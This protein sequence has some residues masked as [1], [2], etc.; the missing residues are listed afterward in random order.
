MFKYKIT[1]L[2]G[3]FMNKLAVL[4]L[5]AN[6]VLVNAQDIMVSEIMQNPAAVGD[7]NGEWF[8]VFNPTGSTIDINGWTI[9][10]DGTNS[11]VIS[12]GGALN[13]VAGGRAVL[14]IDA[15]AATNGGVTCAYQYTG[16]ALANGSDELILTDTVPALRDRVAW[17][18]GA[19]FPDP[20]GASMY[21]VG[22]DTA[23]NNVGANWS[24]S[25]VAYGDGD[26]GSPGTQGA[27]EVPVELMNFEV[28]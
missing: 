4:L 13:V 2:S 9:S 16:I 7:A 12:N 21:F 6:A 28:E 19:T 3:V 17:D 8:E 18:N 23:D 26:L 20:T 24:T 25:G 1:K 10:D 11:H 14:C 27:G 5:L 22:P 15:V